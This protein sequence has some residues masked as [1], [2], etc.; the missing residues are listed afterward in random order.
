LAAQDIVCTF[1]Y[2]EIKVMKVDIVVSTQVWVNKLF[3][4]GGVHWSPKGEQIFRFPVDDSFLMNDGIVDAIEILLSKL[5]G[6]N[7][8]KYEYISHHAQFTPDRVIHGLEEI[9]DVIF[10][11][12][13]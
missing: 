9:F 10:G 8:T 4:E 6:D 3:S 12:A 1:T 5:D 11:E 7:H 2:K 13:K